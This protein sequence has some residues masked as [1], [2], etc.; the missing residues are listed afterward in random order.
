VASETVYEGQSAS[1]TALLGAG[2]YTIYVTP[3]AP[4]PLVSAPSLLLVG[5]GLSDPIK[6]YPTGS[7]S[8]SGPGGL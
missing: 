8:S 1:M 6:A 5:F 2:T 7:G 4:Q 3:I